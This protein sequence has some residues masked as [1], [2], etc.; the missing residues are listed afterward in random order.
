MWSIMSNPIFSRGQ[1][2]FA[3]IV[4]FWRW[5]LDSGKGT[6][7][8]NPSHLG[9]VRWCWQLGTGQRQ[10]GRTRGSLQTSPWAIDSRSQ[11]PMP[12]CMVGLFLLGVGVG[13]G[14]VY[15]NPLF[16]RPSVKNYVKLQLGFW[17]ALQDPI[18]GCESESETHS[19]VSSSFQL[20][21]LHSP[22][23]SPGQNTGVG[24]RSL[25]QGDLPSPGIE[26]RSPALLADSSPAE[27]QEKVTKVHGWGAGFREKF[28]VCKA[29]RRW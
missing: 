21:G 10:G 19:A 3:L 27:P 16:L 6:L 24:S 1:A 2:A 12:S 11:S 4:V 22:W 5:G 15:S 9:E 13:E 8:K 23:N 20:H 28:A 17:C 25:L 26:P 14:R 7:S 18:H 29:I